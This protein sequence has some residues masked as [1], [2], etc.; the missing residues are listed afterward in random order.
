MNKLILNVNMAFN[1]NSIR[2]EHPTI[3]LDPRFDKLALKYGCVVLR[4]HRYPLL[5]RACY[6]V[7]KFR[8]QFYPRKCDIQYD[9]IDNR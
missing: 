1:R 4:G 2:C 9:E 3:L 8:S 7:A 5:T 6:D